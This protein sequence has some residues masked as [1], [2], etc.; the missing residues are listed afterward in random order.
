MSVRRPV[1]VGDPF[2]ELLD[3]QLGSERGLNGEPT[4]TD[5]LLADLP[6]IA[7]AFDELIMPIPDRPDYRAALSTGILVPRAG[8]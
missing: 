4:A 7:T 1:K 5:F 6:P 8:S 2:F 3:Q